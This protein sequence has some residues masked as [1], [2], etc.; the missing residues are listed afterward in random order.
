MFLVAPRAQIKIFVWHLGTF[1]N[2]GR[3][4]CCALPLD[5]CLYGFVDE[6]TQCLGEPVDGVAHRCCL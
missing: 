6:V 1:N 5:G 4:R 3:W 2:S